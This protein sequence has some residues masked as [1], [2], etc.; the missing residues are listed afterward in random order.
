[1]HKVEK[2]LKEL[3]AASQIIS[4]YPEGHPKLQESFTRAYKCLEEAILAYG[5]LK[6]G[7]VEGELTSGKEIFFELSVH[8][9][10]FIENLT[11]KGIGMIT[12]KSSVTQADFIKFLKIISKP[13]D[14]MGDDFCEY[15]NRQ[16]IE[17]ITINKIGVAE[18]STQPSSA[19]AVH[20]G[21][22]EV[23]ARAVKDVLTS[24]V[25]D[26]SSAKRALNGILRQMLE[27][28]WSFLSL[29]Y[30][31][32][33]D[34]STFVHSLNVGALSMFLFHK[35][36][37]KKESIFDVGMAGIFHDIGKLA[38]SRAIIQKPS[39]LTE[40]EM[41][42]MRSHTVLGAEILLQYVDSLGVLPVIVAFEHHLRYDL[43][44]YPRLRYPQKPHFVSLAVSICDCYDALRSR[45]SYKRDYPSEMIYEI[46]LKERGGLFDPQI[47]DEFFRFVG[48]Y[49]IGSIL[50]L[51]NGMIGVVRNQTGDI[52]SPVVEIL[53]PEENRA[54]IINLKERKDIKVKCSLNPFTRGKPFLNML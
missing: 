27:R 35:L 2:F 21:T 36:G 41:E 39:V 44:G 33:H 30:I 45:R 4:L 53:S 40:E 25:I 38:I 22:L 14:G 8:L 23:I 20:R 5:E 3:A 48:V 16:F 34:L 29:S 11:S 28:K 54:D 1:M 15:F 6:I 43:K 7:I 46:M 49:P 18:E 24:E 52:F 42:K 26:P 10:K 12:F 17:G 19:I 31:Q 47:F 37:F 32:K 13:Y 9:K 50:E 51:D